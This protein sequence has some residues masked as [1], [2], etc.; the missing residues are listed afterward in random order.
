MNTLVYAF[1]TLVCWWLIRQPQKQERSW[2]WMLISLITL[3]GYIVAYFWKH[4]M[5]YGPL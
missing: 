5:L 3:V 2:R 4:P 1:M